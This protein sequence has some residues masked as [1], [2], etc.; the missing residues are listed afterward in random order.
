MKLDRRFHGLWFPE[1]VLREAIRAVEKL[2]SNPAKAAVQFLYVA[3]AQDTWV[4]DTLEE[5]FSHLKAADGAR[6]S[7]EAP[8][9]KGGASC[10]L[11]YDKSGRGSSVEVTSPNLADIHSVMNVFEESLDRAIKIAMD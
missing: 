2:S 9:A 10:K 1:S 7:F 11:T 5:F 3:T 6:F 8:L 4:L